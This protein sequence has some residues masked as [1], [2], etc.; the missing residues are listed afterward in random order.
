MN[1][2]HTFQTRY[3]SYL[4]AFCFLLFAL[5]LWGTFDQGWWAKSIWASASAGVSYR[6]TV[7]VLLL[8]GATG[9]A[10]GVPLPLLLLLPIMVFV[11]LA[12]IGVAAA[13]AWFWICATLIGAVLLSWCRD[14]S[15]PV[16][17]VRSSAAGFVVTGSTIGI[18]AHFPINTPVV[19]MSLISCAGLLATWRL[20][21]FKGERASILGT[22]LQRRRRSVPEICMQAIILVGVALVLFVTALPEVGHDALAVHLTIPARMLDSKRWDFDVTQYIWSVMPFGANWLML[23]PYF[24]AGEQA[25]KLMDSSFVLAT[26][27]LS[28]R[29]LLPRIG[30]AA[31]LAAPALLLTL[32]LTMLVSGSVFVEPAIAFLFLLC[33][34]ELTGTADKDQGGWLF[35]AAVAGYLCASKL[36]GVPL[37]PILLLAACVLSREGRFQRASVGI[38]LAAVFLFLLIGAQPYVVAYFQTGNP[39]FPFYNTIF[40]SPYFTAE[41]VFN[42]G[43]AFA[44]PLYLRPLNMGMFWDSSLKSRIFGEFGADGAIGIVFL[45]LVPLSF[46]AAFLMRRWWVLGGL[47]AT[48]F[49]CVLVF[50]TQAYLRYIYQVLPWFVVFGVWAL[51]RL[52]RPGLTSTLLVVLLCL[53]SLLRFPVVYGPLGQFSPELMF[54]RDAHRGMLEKSKPSVIVGDV[55]QQLEHLRGKQ[56]LLIGTDPVY[57]HFPAGTIAFSWHSWPFFS[58]PDRD[59]N[60]KKLIREFNIELIV[61]PVGQNEPHEAEILAMTNEVFVENGIRAGL[62]KTE[63]AYEVERVVGIELAKPNPAWQLGNNIAKNGGVQVTVS[64]PIT[65]AIEVK[66]RRGLL[67]MKVSCPEGKYFRSQ[68][69]WLDTKPGVE[70]SNI[71]VHACHGDVTTIERVLSIPLGVTKGVVYGSSHDEGAVIIRG[72]SFRTTH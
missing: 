31:A 59:S 40:K 43:H 24:L 42:N 22:L 34:A 62:V 3:S 35:L 32:P 36:L 53:V 61:H 67:Q 72:V 37:L 55:I 50:Q 25:A 28:Y 8:L 20:G 11:G 63:D 56:T 10:I 65:Q 27:W 69:N 71:E 30:H 47:I 39:L 45:V 49:Y 60:F 51:T 13:V 4:T 2:E 64:H 21:L 18:M 66:G 58:S 54:D 1:T 7:G 15:C 57:S 68:I 19:Y 23:P 14:E 5:A 12:G 46:A 41:S 26:A 29:I 9:L 70:G 6:W 38:L 16:W 48:T 52:S 44:N 33:F 17:S